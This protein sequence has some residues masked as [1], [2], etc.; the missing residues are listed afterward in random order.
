MLSKAGLWQALSPL[1]WKASI[2]GDG[3]VCGWVMQWLPWEVLETSGLTGLLGL[4]RLVTVSCAVIW[5][6]CKH[7]LTVQEGQVLVHVMGLPEWQG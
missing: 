6:C 2:L 1:I 3:W 5:E 7:R 4:C